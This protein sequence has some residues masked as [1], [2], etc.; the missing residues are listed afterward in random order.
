MNVMAARVDITH[1]RRKIC[2]RAIIKRA[3]AFAMLV[4]ILTGAGYFLVG[5]HYTALDQVIAGLVGALLGAGSA[6]WS[7]QSRHK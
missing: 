4:M 6:W 3:P 2:Y 5:S 1:S 7:S